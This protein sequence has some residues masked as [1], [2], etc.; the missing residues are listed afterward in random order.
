MH[1]SCLRALGGSHWRRHSPG[2][3]STGLA[4]P[5]EDVVVDLAGFLQVQATA[6]TGIRGRCCGAVDRLRPPGDYKARRRWAALVLG[7]AR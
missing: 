2:R 3:W 7:G 6:R 1:P 5:R 4:D